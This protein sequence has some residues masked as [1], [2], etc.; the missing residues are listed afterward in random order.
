MAPPRAKSGFDGLRIHRNRLPISEGVEVQDVHPRVG[1]NAPLRVAAAMDS[2]Q[3][4]FGMDSVNDFFQVRH[5]V[6]AA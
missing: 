4:T 1:Q 6:L 2:R 5:H 3:P